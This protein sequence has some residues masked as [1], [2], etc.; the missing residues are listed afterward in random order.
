MKKGLTLVLVVAMLL[1]VMA[2]AMAESNLTVW[3]NHTW[4][5][6]DEFVGVIPDTIKEKTGTTL[7]PTRALDDGQLGAMIASG[8]LLDLTFTDRELNRLSTPELCYSYNEL[9]EKYCPD[10]QPD[11]VAIANAKAYSGDDNY[12]FLFSHAYTTEQWQRATAGVPSMGSLVY[13]YD[14][15]KELGF[16]PTTF[17]TI[18]E[19]DALYAA[20]HEKYPDM[21]ILSYGPVTG[22]QYFE[23]MFGIS[24]HTKWIDNGDG[25][26]SHV[27]NSVNFEKE[28]RKLNEYYRLGYINPDCFAYDEATADGYMYSN[29]LFSYVNSTQGY[30]NSFTLSGRESTGNPDFTVLEMNPLGDEFSVRLASLGWC[31]TFISRNCKDP[32][33]AIKLMRYLFSDEGA[34]LT[35]CGREGIEHTMDETGIP[36]FSQEWI[37]ATGDEELFANKYNTNFYFGTTGLIEAVSRTC[38]LPEEYQNTYALLRQRV[39]CE[40]WYTLAE[41][42]DPDS[43]EYI[44]SA[45]LTDMLK[46]ATASLILSDNDESFEANLAALRENARKAGI[47]ELTEYMNRE[48]PAKAALYQE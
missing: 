47:D 11:P 4:Y 8:E 26:Y 14:I 37:D 40:P 41:P 25:T 16:D 18:E 9:I 27:I 15:A 34:M 28:M 6:T 5:P 43:D 21:E 42:K 23:F 22:L 48:I 1:S 30:A 13:R 10:W 29:K 36:R 32:E 7:T 44:I 46:S 24:P 3:L 45:K 12:Y 20:V 38:T 33:A 19:L 39:V 2:P 35:M 17:T 31:G